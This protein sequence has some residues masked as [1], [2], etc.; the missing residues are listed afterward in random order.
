M[1]R[2][3]AKRLA[4]SYP[5]VW[6]ARYGEEYDALLDET[7]LRWRD[8]AD[9]AAG[10]LDAHLRQDTTDTEETPMQ[11]WKLRL[12]RWLTTLTA[13]LFGGMAALLFI[14]SYGIVPPPN[15]ENLTTVSGTLLSIGGN[16][17]ADSDL[18]IRLHG[19]DTLFYINRFGYAASDIRT[20][21]G[22]NTEVTLHIFERYIGV[23]QPLAQLGNQPTIMIS[24]DAGDFHP[25]WYNPQAVSHT[26]HRV[27]T[28]LVAGV[29]MMVA[30]GTWLLRRT[31]LQP[32]TRKRK[33]ALA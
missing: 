25:D 3:L 16:D 9:I 31:L 28:R 14:L 19:Y 15:P 18:T 12:A 33:L 20:A 32:P 17:A 27:Q 6:R 8:V 11:T 23:A 10:S 7:E 26:D 22:Y 21:I 2:W 1:K 30:I 4:R 24:S 29:L 5:R 13:L